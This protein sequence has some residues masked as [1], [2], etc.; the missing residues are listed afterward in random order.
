MKHGNA[1]GTDGIKVKVWKSLGEEWVDLFFY[2]VVRSIT[3]YVR[4]G[5]T[6]RGMEIQ[7]YRT[8]L[9][10]DGAIQGWWN[11]RGIKMISHI[12]WIF[13]KDSH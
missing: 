3:E 4:A 2:Y 13:G 9:Q 11:Y 7:Y 8:T 5:E 10:R 6:T 12:P 1:M